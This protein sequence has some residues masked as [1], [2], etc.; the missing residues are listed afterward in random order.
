MRRDVWSCQRRR[1]LVWNYLCV[2][3]KAEASIR[4]RD[5][6]TLSAINAGL[7]TP[8]SD[9]DKDRNVIIQAPTSDGR[10]DRR[11]RI[12]LWNYLCLCLCVAAQMLI[13]VKKSRDVSISISTGTL[14]L[15][16][17]LL[18]TLTSSKQQQRFVFFSVQS[19]PTPMHDV[20]VQQQQQC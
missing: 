6:Y 7:Q 11:R 15:F 10:P 5:H 17:P 19:H 1:M 2:A 16:D 18:G 12:L 8:T 14:S 20:D 9:N 3:A 13:E 4:R